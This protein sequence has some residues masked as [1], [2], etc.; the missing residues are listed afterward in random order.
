MDPYYLR[1]QK[2]ACAQLPNQT[3][4]D[5]FVSEATGLGDWVKRNGCMECRWAAQSAGQPLDQSERNNAIFPIPYF[6]DLRH[7]SLDCTLF[8]STTIHRNSASSGAPPSESK[9]IHYI[10]CSSSSSSSSGGTPLDPPKECRGERPPT[11]CLLYT[12]DAADE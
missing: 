5:M 7:D 6:G 12:S 8:G 10:L 11:I 2:H 4:I 3:H 9:L 1:K